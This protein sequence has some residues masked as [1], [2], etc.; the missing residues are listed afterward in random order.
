MEYANLADLQ[1]SLMQIIRSKEARFR[2]R[3]NRCVGD[4]R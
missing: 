3:M 1:R 2:S 4:E